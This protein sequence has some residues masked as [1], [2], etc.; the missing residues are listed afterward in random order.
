MTYRTF[1]ANYLI[2]L[3]S[4]SLNQR[5]TP[6][7]VRATEWR[8][9]Y[10]LAEYHDVTNIAYYSLIGLYDQIPE[11]WKNRFSKIFRKWVSNG[12]VQTKE[13]TAVMEAL[14]ED[15]ID[16]VMLKDWILSRYYPQT[17]MRVVED[18]AILIR[19]RDIKDVQYTMRELG[20]HQEIDPEDGVISFFKKGTYRIVFYTNLFENNRKFS[21]YYNKVWKKLKSA[22]GF[23]VRYAFTVD[24]FYVYMLADICDLYARGEVDAR[25]IVDLHLYRKKHGEELDRVYIEMELNKLELF[26]MA[27][28]LE[29][30]ADL[31]FGVYEGEGIRQC[32]DVEE[33][34]WSKGAYGRETSIQLLPMINDSKIWRIRDARKKKIIKVL[35]WFFPKLEKMK[36]RYPSVQQLKILLPVYWIMRLLSMIFFLVKINFLRIRRFITIKL[37]ERWGKDEMME[38]EFLNQLERFEKESLEEKTP[39]EKIPEKD[40]AK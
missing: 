1:E 5:S 38:L 17:D 20:F 25:S 22:V 18:V 21:Q 34:I 32:K 6:I 8:E 14:E 12:E 33:Y 37:H 27:E 16:Y 39:Q 11:R 10:Y 15:L 36:G 28:C 19:Q 30:L 13:V 2:S 3:I 7:P 31:W 23:G 24:D 29:S 4:A 9:L 40:A 26:K 35:R